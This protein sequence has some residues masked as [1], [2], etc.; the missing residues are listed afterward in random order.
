MKSRTILPL[1]MLV[2][3]LFAVPSLSQAIE[4]AK[5]ISDREIIESLAELKAGHKSI[6]KRMDY[7][8]K[9]MDTLEKR[10]DAL[11]RRMEGFER[12]ME[13]FERRMEAMENSFNRRMDG[14]QSM[15]MWCMGIM[16]TGMLSIVGFVLWDRRTAIN[17][18][19]ST[20]QR[21]QEELEKEKRHRKELEE[22]LA[23]L[24]KAL[25]EYTKE[26]HQPIGI[27]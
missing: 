11:E 6:E 27:G 18:V 21:L 10:M 24:A 23:T 8:E 17:P 5:R 7:L 25:K 2:L 20:T 19:I 9:R 12:R 13:G 1:M 14:L 22:R 4:P 3:Y 26:A 15:L 16:A